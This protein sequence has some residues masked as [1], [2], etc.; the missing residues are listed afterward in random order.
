MIASRLTEEMP[1]EL[2]EAAAPPGP[3]AAPLGAAVFIESAGRTVYGWLHT[4]PDGATRDVAVLICSPLGWDETASYR[5]RRVWAES[6]A[7]AGYATLRFDLPATGDSEGDPADADLL[8][9]WRSSVAD[10]ARWLRAATGCD[11][12]AGVGMG[13]GGLLLAD[14]MAGDAPLDDLALWATPARGRSLVRELRTFGA[15]EASARDAAEQAFARSP[16]DLSDRSDGPDGTVVAG[17]FVLCGET[18]RALESFD[19][20]QRD[21][22][23]AERRRVL[24]LERD[25][26][27]PDARLMRWLEGQ[28]T[29]VT[30]APGDGYGT[31]T[32]QPYSAPPPEEVIART[33]DWLAEVSTPA[34]DLCP[35]LP[36]AAAQFVGRGRVVREAALRIAHGE[37]RLEGMLCEPVEA[38]VA[39]LGLIFT[40]VG[41]M[42]RTGPG[43][44]W[45]RAARRWAARGVPSLRLDIAG[46]ADS[47]DGPFGGDGHDGNISRLYEPGIAAQ[48]GAVVAELHA[49]GVARRF[50]VIGVCSGAYWGFQCALKDERISAVVM[51]NPAALIWN[52][53]LEATRE[54]RKLLKLRKVSQWRRIARGGVRTETIVRVARSALRSVPR[55][56]LRFPGRL[57]ARSRAKV[58]GSD[59]IDSAFDRLRERDQRV[60][61]AFCSV[62]EPLLDELCSQRGLPD[63]ERWP[64]VEVE[65][66]PGFDHLL[67]PPGMQEDALRILDRA[68]ERE[69]E[70]S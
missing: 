53:M 42:R 13:L 66:I 7:L 39:E 38:P 64:N 26:M 16:D 35:A 9:A 65:L 40:N 55:A 2:P 47:W 46:I 50:V 61:L 4:P 60:V 54:A 1:T 52:P 41:G 58:T 36:P 11:R 5:P 57:F 68:L 21:P 28:G 17:G 51:L 12:L 49:R 43:R 10:A 44:M 37:V 31:M 45:V 32:G 14:A 22:S 33:I 18:V 69:L 20:T 25:G 56:V 23:P 70:R 8:G 27:G 19:V 63:P 48:V 59:E 6:L 29:E 30:V 3:A 34:P 15:M 62:G 67:R 24:L